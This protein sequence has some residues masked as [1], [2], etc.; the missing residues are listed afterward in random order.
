MAK[1]SSTVDERL[2]ALERAI[3]EYEPIFRNLRGAACC[4][5]I[6]ACSQ[7]ASA[8]EQISC[9]RRWWKGGDLVEQVERLVCAIYDVPDD[10]ADQIV[11][12]AVRRAS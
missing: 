8:T 10:L 6:S 5:R 12:H 2:K 9:R 11:A 7:C 1:V 3:D 4:R